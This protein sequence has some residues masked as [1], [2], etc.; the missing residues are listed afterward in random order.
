MPR[1]NLVEEFYEQ[2]KLSYPDFTFEQINEICLFPYMYFKRRMSDDDIPDIRVKYLGSWQVFSK[3]VLD[4]LKKK[5]VSIKR[6]Q[7]KG[8]EIYPNE[9]QELNKLK[10]YVEDNPKV[11][12]KV[13]KRRNT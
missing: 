1:N 9:I 2:I 11:F 12:H 8:E 10:K 5:E 6:R 13:D 7:D 3:P 4:R